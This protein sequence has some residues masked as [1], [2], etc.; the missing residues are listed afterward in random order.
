MTG[1]NNTV[2][3]SLEVITSKFDVLSSGVARLNLAQNSENVQLPEHFQNPHLQDHTQRLKRSANKVL[4]TASTLLG[5]SSAREDDSQYIPTTFSEF[6]VPLD[7]ARRAGIEEWTRDLVIGIEESTTESSEN[8]EDPSTSTDQNA[9]SS[10]VHNSVELDD[11]PDVVDIEASRRRKEAEIK[12][13]EPEFHAI[14]AE[15]IPYQGRSK[16]N[17][18]VLK[19]K[20]RE[21]GSAEWPLVTGQPF[22]SKPAAEHTPGRTRSNAKTE[23]PE[24]RY[25]ERG[26]EHVPSKRSTQAK[27]RGEGV[28]PIYARE[29]AEEILLALDC[30]IHSIHFDT[31][32]ALGTVVA[33]CDGTPIGPGQLAKRFTPVPT[34]I[35]ASVEHL[36]SMRA[37]I[38]ALNDDG[39]A[40]LHVAAKRGD[41]AIATTLCELGADLD[42]A[43]GGYS[44]KI[45][46]HIAAEKGHTAL[47]VLLL[48]RGAFVDTKDSAKL[49][50]L[51]M[52]AF[53]N[54]QLD[55]VKVLCDAG[56]D[57]EARS[58]LG[59][60]PLMF[61][62]RAVRSNVKNT[63]EIVRELCERGADVPE[64]TGEFSVQ[65]DVKKVLNQYQARRKKDGRIPRRQ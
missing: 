38:N 14:A 26:A 56:A 51:H 20:L 8:C 55:V 4:T 64:L 62:I 1:I 23:I 24:L 17:D 43:G 61:S 45:A 10:K 12:E 40:P 59:T 18:D 6:G 36:Y 3:P 54:G 9:A 33:K 46:L 7:N 44:S 29:F 11:S 34:Q 5:G 60:T 53:H 28:R 57:F 48:E 52:A 22:D 50:P 15:R 58:E 35:A 37:D 19:P 13:A 41:L 32:H 31:T 16:L 42:L 47:V 30:N 65:K 25:L 39:W 49:T 21:K 27:F 63:L 2:I